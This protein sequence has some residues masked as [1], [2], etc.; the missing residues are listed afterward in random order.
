MGK[1]TPCRRKPKCCLFL[2]SQRCPA[3]NICHVPEEPPSWEGWNTRTRG[4]LPFSLANFVLPSSIMLMSRVHTI[5][6]LSCW[7]RWALKKLLS[8][9]GIGGN[10]V[11]IQ[12]S[13]ISTHLHFH[14]APGEVPDETK[15]CYYPCRTFCG[16]GQSCEHRPKAGTSSCD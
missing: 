12:S 14:C 11:A 3:E 5:D 6:M 13:R 4:D 10:L 8:C 15:G 1:T 2:M 16:T 9:P 7:G